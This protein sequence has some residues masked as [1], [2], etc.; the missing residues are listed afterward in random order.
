MLSERA[1]LAQIAHTWPYLSETLLGVCACCEP[2]ACVSPLQ[3]PA[4]LSRRCP[5]CGPSSSRRYWR[6]RRPYVT[7]MRGKGPGVHP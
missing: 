2:L 6:R 1:A 5:L 4:T 7:F 3:R